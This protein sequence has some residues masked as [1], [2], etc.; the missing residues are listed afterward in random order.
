L[1]DL[2]HALSADPGMEEM[3][4]RLDRLIQRIS[5]K[6]GGQA[7]HSNPTLGV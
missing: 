4:K 3:R 1:A 2:Q 7:S 6:A 5:L